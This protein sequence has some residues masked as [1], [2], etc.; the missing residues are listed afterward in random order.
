MKDIELIEEQLNSYIDG[1]LDERKSNEVRRLIDNDQQV[2]Q[3]FESLNR[4]KQLMNSIRSA[5]APEGFSESIARHLE[6]HILLADPEVYHHKTGRRHLVL[7]RVLTAAAIFVLLAVL[8]MVVLD[9]FIPKAS[10]DIFVSKVLNRKQ[11]PQV[12]YEKPIAQTPQLVQDQPVIVEKGPAVPMVAKLT[13]ATDSPVE[14]DWLIGKALM[15][16]GLFDKTVA[17]DRKANS[18]KYVLNC[19]RDSLVNFVGELAF[20]W[21]KCNDAALEIGTEQSGKYISVNNITARQTLDICKA[22]TYN[23]RIRMANDIAVINNVAAEDV[24]NRYFAGRNTDLNLL[25][26][27]KPVLTSAEKTQPIKPDVSESASL[28]IIVT[29]N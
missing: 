6:R 11:K 25:I 29:G 16:T 14:T 21:P 8:S 9:V 19:G 27:D 2:R 18:V 26:P 28:T 22:A 24:L 7:R 15:N 23:Q 17:V 3:L 1:E 4:Y 5:T 13:L 20:V 10:R 12:L